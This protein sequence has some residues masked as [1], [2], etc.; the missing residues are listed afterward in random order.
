[1]KS[2][3]NTA[4]AVE[5]TSWP[6]TLE[7]MPEHVWKN[8]AQP[9]M[10]EVWRSRGFLVQIYEERTVPRLERVT[11]CRTTLDLAT[12]RWKDG[13]T[14]DELQAIKRDVGRGHLD[15]VEIYPNDADMV[16]V[17]N[18]RHLWVLEYPLPFAWRK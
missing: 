12:G 18:M 3:D 14:W 16:N 9:N 7:R 13:I 15:A 5:N 8:L 10:I 11:V 17:S 1:M 2:A 4:H 6:T